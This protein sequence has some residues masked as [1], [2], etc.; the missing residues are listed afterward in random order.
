M[1]SCGRHEFLSQ[2]ER[3]RNRWSSPLG[4]KQSVMARGRREKFL[5]TRAACTKNL[6]S[7]AFV[8][9]VQFSFA[10]LVLGTIEA[11]PDNSITL[12]PQDNETINLCIEFKSKLYGELWEGYVGVQ[13]NCSRLRERQTIDDENVLLRN[14]YP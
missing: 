2:I 4:N 13:S 9:K 14:T 12:R 7:G 11:N 10:E 5:P 3:N 8:R 1:G 6:N